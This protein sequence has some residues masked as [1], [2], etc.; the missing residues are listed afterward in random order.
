MMHCKHTTCV[1]VLLVCMF[2]YWYYSNIE[3]HTANVIIIIVGSTTSKVY[4]CFLSIRLWWHSKW[5]FQ[6]QKTINV[7]Q[8][9]WASRSLQWVECEGRFTGKEGNK[10]LT[11]PFCVRNGIIVC[12]RCTVTVTLIFAAWF[13]HPRWHLPWQP[14]DMDYPWL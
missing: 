6:P 10:S 13:L 12:M 14:G 1:I 9:S 11:Q 3:L 2:W 8:I 4:I 7:V 5:D